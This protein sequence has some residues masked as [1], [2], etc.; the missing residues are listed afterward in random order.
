[1]FFFPLLG[2]W[3]TPPTDSK[4]PPWTVGGP[5]SVYNGLDSRLNV[6]E[7]R[8]HRAALRLEIG[9]TEPSPIKTSSSA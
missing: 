3:G 9:P 5:I 8:G 1:M 7:P 2:A 4:V 6:L